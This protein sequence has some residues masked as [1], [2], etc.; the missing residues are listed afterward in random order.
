MITKGV[1]AVPMIEFT[2]SA[3]KKIEAI[4][5]KVP[6]DAKVIGWNIRLEKE[7][8]HARTYSYELHVLHT[9]NL[10][11]KEEQV[12]MYIVEGAVVP[13]MTGNLELICQS[14][15]NGRVLFLFGVE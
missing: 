15:V 3:D 4:K 10:M 13:R 6:W 1:S 5:L 2:V 11:A 12:M 8:P 7:G 14:I 9:N